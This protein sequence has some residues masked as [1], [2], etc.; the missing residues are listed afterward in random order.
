VPKGEI[1]LGQSQ[2]SMMNVTTFVIATGQGRDYPWQCSDAQ[3][4]QQ[5]VNSIQFM[6]YQANESIQKVLF[7]SL[8]FICSF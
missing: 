7:L 4:T 3:T 2:V 6:I 1:F 8:V 5:W